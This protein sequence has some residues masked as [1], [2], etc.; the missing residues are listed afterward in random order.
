MPSR[1]SSAPPTPFFPSPIV[2]EPQNTELILAFR[3]PS[4]YI[5]DSADK[6]SFPAAKAELHALLEKPEL[7]GIPVLVRCSPPA[8]SALAD[9]SPFWTL[10]QVLGNKNDLPTH[11][12]V[13]ELIAAL[14]L[15]SIANREVSCYS[16]SGESS[17]SPI[18]SLSDP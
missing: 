16:V 17:C 8:Y 1:G 12:K 7:L 4:S 14:G 2:H 5:V 18:L 3:R 15:A 6:D 13:D 11:A 10:E 9:P